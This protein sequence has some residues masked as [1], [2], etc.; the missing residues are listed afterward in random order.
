MLRTHGC[1]LLAI[2][3][4][5]AA[6][7][8]LLSSAIASDQEAFRTRPRVLLIY[9]ESSIL[10]AVARVDQAIRSRFGAS[11]I[12]PEFFTEYLDLSWAV[13]ERY[14]ERLLAFLSA[15]HRDRKFDVVIPGGAEALRFVLA[16]RA[17]LF[18]GAP[19]VFCAV[20]PGIVSERDLPPDVTGVWMTFDGAA[21]IEAA[22]RLQPTARRVVIVGGAATADRLYLDGVKRQLAGRGNDLEISYLQ[23]LPLE[24]VRERLARLSPDTIVFYLSIQ[25]DGAGQRLAPKAFISRPHRSQ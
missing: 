12:N 21:T 10:P 9:T 17:E 19:I 7:L 18:A 15:K 2:L 1:P 8:G 6:A 3:A 22:T 4:A 11:G 13:D 20:P 5:L 14:A 23:G 24:Q 25:R 16:H